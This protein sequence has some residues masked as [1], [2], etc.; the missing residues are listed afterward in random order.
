MPVQPQTVGGRGYQ[1]QRYVPPSTSKPLRTSQ[2]AAPSVQYFD[3]AESSPRQSS[4]KRKMNGHGDEEGSPEPQTKK[5]KKDKV[6]DETE[7]AAK[8]SEKE[9][10]SKKKEQTEEEKAA[11]KGRKREKKEKKAKQGT[12]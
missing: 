4:P 5:A 1:Y 7:S 9:K 11:R 12:L 10:K 3:N 8:S 6:K 2:P